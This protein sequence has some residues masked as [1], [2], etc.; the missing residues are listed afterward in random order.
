MKRERAWQTGAAALLQHEGAPLN[1]VARHA[2]A[3]AITAR[4][5]PGW[6][7]RAAQRGSTIWNPAVECAFATGTDAMVGRCGENR[8]G[9][10]AAFGLRSILSD[11]FGV[12]ASQAVRF[13]KSR[14]APWSVGV[15]HL[16]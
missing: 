13:E 6:L 2:A 11:H 14:V 4:G 1:G 16:F 10:A 7:C 5:H 9:S 8:S 15:N 3:P 12:N